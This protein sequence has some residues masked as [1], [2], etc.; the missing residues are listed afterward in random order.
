MYEIVTLGTIKIEEV[1]R[2]LTLPLEHV[3]SYFSKYDLYKKYPIR[4]LTFQEEQF[5]DAIKDVKL[6]GEQELKTIIDEYEINLKDLEKDQLL[7]EKKLSKFTDEEA[8]KITRKYQHFILEPAI[9]YGNKEAPL[10]RP[11]DMESVI[12]MLSNIAMG[13]TTQK[14]EL[15]PKVKVSALAKIADIYTASKALSIGNPD[16][17]TNED[18]NELSPKEL[19]KLIAH[20]KTKTSKEEVVETKKEKVETPTEHILFD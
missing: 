5:V 17:I 14:I 10:T 15:D 11:L 6:M 16:V 3:K 2:D 20:V 12:T 4:D 18:L 8:Y 19:T 7:I 13:L 9:I 1:A